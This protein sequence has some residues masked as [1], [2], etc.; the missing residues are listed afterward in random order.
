MNNAR[1]QGLDALRGIAALSVLAFHLLADTL[2]QGATNAYLGVDFFFLL[3]GYLMARTYEGRLAANLSAWAFLRLRYVRLWPVMACSMVIGLPFVVGVYGLS[4]KTAAAILLNFALL[5]SFLGGHAFAINFPAWSI[6]FELAAN[7]FHGLIVWRVRSRLLLLAVGALLLSFILH[8]LDHPL[9]VGMDSGSFLAGF[10]R[11]LLTYLLGIWLYRAFGDV[12]PICVPAWVT[13][14]LMPTIFFGTWLIEFNSGWLD[15]AFAVLVCPLLLVG[16]MRLRPNALLRWLGRISFP[17]YA[18]HMPIMALLIFYRLP[19][20][21][22]V[23]LAFAAAEIVSQLT[24]RQ[25]R[26]LVSDDAAG[27]AGRATQ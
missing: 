22:A 1:L 18:V 5:P 24:N 14:L 2:G 7:L 9:S 12:A 8:G 10:R 13:I 11:V 27:L 3:S 15:L 16:G 21:W 23:P 17:L 26:K 4:W 20:L 6:F 25:R 19:V